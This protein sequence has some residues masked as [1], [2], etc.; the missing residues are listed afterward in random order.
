[1]ACS[2]RCLGS[3]SHQFM[4]VIHPVEKQLL[5]CIWYDITCLMQIKGFLH[6]IW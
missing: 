3:P 2:S 6:G 4:T 1:M 5:E